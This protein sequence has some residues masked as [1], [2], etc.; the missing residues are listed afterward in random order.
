[1]ESGV[2]PNSV[3]VSMASD[4]P[5]DLDVLFEFGLARFLDGV[6]VLIP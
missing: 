1:M 6:G 4:V 3:R 2:F 5:F